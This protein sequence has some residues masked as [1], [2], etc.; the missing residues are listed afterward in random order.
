MTTLFRVLFQKLIVLLAHLLL[1]VA[2]RLV[3]TADKLQPHL[4]AK[5]GN[6]QASPEETPKWPL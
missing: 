6:A 1:D 3:A 2:I 4:N 5:P